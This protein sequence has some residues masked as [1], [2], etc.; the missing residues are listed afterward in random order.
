MKQV[1]ILAGGKGTRLQER[2]GGLPKPLIDIGGMPLL[3]RQVLLA[4]RFG[5][6]EVLLLVSHAADQIVDFCAR[7]NNWGINIRCIDDGMPRGTAGATLAVFEQLHDEFLVMY[8]DTML[9]VDLERFHA[10]HAQ[11]SDAAATL[12]LHPNDHPR[13]SD[14]VDIDDDGTVL[15]FH[16]YPH[17]ESRYYRNLVNAALYWVR[18][19]AL[20]SWVGTPGMLDFG[21]DLFPAMLAQGA[22]LRGYVSPEYIK[23][24]GTPARLDRVCA[25]LASGKISRS[26]LSNPQPV[27]FIDRDGTLN[28]EVNHLKHHSELHLLPGVAQAIRRLNESD[29]R[30]CVVTNQPVVAR[31]ECLFADLREI[32]NKLDWLLGRQGAYVDRLYYCPHHPDKGFA[33]ERPELKTECAC[34]KPGT[35]MID[36]AVVDLNVSRE[37]SW[38]IGDSSVDMA[39]ARNAGIR[40]I[41]VET[42]YAGLDYRSWIAPDFSMPDLSQAVNFVLE[43]FPEMLEN[44][45]R[46]TEGIEPRSVVLL[47][48]QARS[49]KSNLASVLRCALEQRGQRTVVLALDRW[50]LSEDERGDGVLG[51]YELGRVQVLLEQLCERSKPMSITLPGYHRLERRRVEAVETVSVLPADVV[52]IE[53]TVA[54]ALAVP[55]EKSTHRYHLELAEDLRRQRMIREYL[56][57]GC[58]ERQASA[59][60]D[61]RIAD[62]FPIVE[63]LACNAERLSVAGRIA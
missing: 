14:L 26:V 51:R 29:Y 23:D 36:Q 53:G 27:V 38:L 19:S 59:I 58:D 22:G 63:Q 60:Y 25:D 45:R 28:E 32:H 4:R 62:E 40:S 30:C 37:R 49:G 46:L 50:L 3:E 20:A 54:L 48:G 9:E 10:F 18:K 52:L 6:G 39:T 55:R 16:P 47:G 15:G 61:R 34:R 43:S 33:G 7:R 56:L 12:F 44:A 21:K 13:D 57:R 5:F 31:G 8:G 2:L 35:G 1:V 42:G 17:D 41:L 11:D 24:A